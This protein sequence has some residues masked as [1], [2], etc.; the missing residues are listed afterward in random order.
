MTSYVKDILTT[1]GY[2]QT[3]TRLAILDV[4]TSHPTPLS[5]AEITKRAQQTH[6]SLNR[7]TVYRTLHQFH[8]DGLIHQI[9]PFPADIRY[10]LSAR[11][12]TVPH[13]HIICSHCGKIEDFSCYVNTTSPE[14]IVSQSEQFSTPENHSFE[15]FALC[16][17]CTE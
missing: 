12:Q 15:I 2:K 13:H 8:K 10:E 3:Q 16:K 5:E 6:P 14:V 9:A 1:Y 4:L 7:S 11:L 17:E